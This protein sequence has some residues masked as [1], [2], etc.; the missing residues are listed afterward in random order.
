MTDE[1]EV[2]AFVETRPRP[3]PRCREAAQVEWRRVLSSV[4]TFILVQTST[5]TTQIS[6][7][8][9]AVNTHATLHIKLTNIRVNTLG[10]LEHTTCISECVIFLLCK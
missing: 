7:D 2:I 4:H 6:Q 3:R 10:V 1:S 8:S 5:W 9:A